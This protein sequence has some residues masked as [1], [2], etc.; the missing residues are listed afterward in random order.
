MKMLMVKSVHALTLCLK[1][2]DSARNWE[3]KV[4]SSFFTCL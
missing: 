4:E 3:L 2:F 1:A